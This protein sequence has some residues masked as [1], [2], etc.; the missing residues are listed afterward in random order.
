MPILG[1]CICT[2]CKK[3][4]TVKPNIILNDTIYSALFTSPSLACLTD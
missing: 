1:S 3:T 2:Q 4:T